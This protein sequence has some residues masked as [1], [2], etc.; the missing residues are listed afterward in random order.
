MALPFSSISFGNH[1]LPS[2]PAIAAKVKSP[3]LTINPLQEIR[4]RKIV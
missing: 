2:Q 4:K 3:I 1:Q